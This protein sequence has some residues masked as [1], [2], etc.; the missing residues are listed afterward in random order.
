MVPEDS[1][2]TLTIENNYNT[3]IA[4]LVDQ[5]QSAG[6]YSVDL[7]S[8]NLLAGVYYYTLEARGINNNHY[9]KSTKKMLLIK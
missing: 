1:H 8:S 6:Y 2:V 9:Y 4:K 5:D 3:M 7:S